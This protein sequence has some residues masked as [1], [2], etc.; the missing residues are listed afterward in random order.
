MPFKS[1]NWNEQFIENH[2]SV[3]LP[4]FYWISYSQKTVFFRKSWT[5]G[6]CIELQQEDTG[7]PWHSNG[8]RGCPNKN[9]H[10]GSDYRTHEGCV[11]Y[12]QCRVLKF[13]LG[14]KL[15]FFTWSHNRSNANTLCLLSTVCKEPPYKVEESGYAGFL[16]PIEVYFKNKVRCSGGDTGEE[17]TQENDAGFC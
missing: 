5:S 17:Q 10:S 11:I 4:P 16:M 7:R 1:S 2:N 15:L 8:L 14:E 13:N 9:K 6:S 12:M 3:H